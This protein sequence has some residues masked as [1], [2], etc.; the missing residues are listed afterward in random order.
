MRLLR[1]KRCTRF[2]TLC[3]L[4][5][6]AREQSP[7]LSKKKMVSNGWQKVRVRQKLSARTEKV[8]VPLLRTRTFPLVWNFFSSAISNLLV[9]WY[10]YECVV[11]GLANDVKLVQ[12]NNCVPGYGHTHAHKDSKILGRT[13]ALLRDWSLLRQALL[14]A[15]VDQRE[16]F[17]LPGLAECFIL[18]TN[19]ETGRESC[20]F[21]APRSPDA[22]SVACR[23]DNLVP[24]L[25]QALFLFLSTL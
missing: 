20:K 3:A 5:R 22:V 1:A 17:L 6:R 24:A 13:L 9:D 10:S 23:P 21:Q 8:S 14:W 25:K 2:V 7:T 4:V 11:I 18:T 16:F 19:L 15:S 12:N